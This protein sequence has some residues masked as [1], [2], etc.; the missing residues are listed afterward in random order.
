MPKAILKFNLPEEQEDF[1]L[2]MKAQDLRSAICMF[3]DFLRTHVKYGA[4]EDLNTDTVE[5]VREELFRLL[6][7]YNVT[8]LF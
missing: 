3:R 7:E 2:T 8:N 1:D 4:R 5:K 6:D